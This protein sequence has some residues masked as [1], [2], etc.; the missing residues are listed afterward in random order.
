MREALKDIEATLLVLDLGVFHRVCAATPDVRPED[1]PGGTA[2]PRLRVMTYME[3]VQAF[4]SP[5]SAATRMA[6]ALRDN[7]VP[8]SPRLVAL[9]DDAPQLVPAPVEPLPRAPAAASAGYREVFF[10][11]LGLDRSH[12]RER[13]RKTFERSTDAI[14]LACGDGRQHVDLF[15]QW[16]VRW[17]RSTRKVR[18]IVVPWTRGHERPESEYGWQSL[19]ATALGQGDAAEALQAA[20]QVAP[21]LIE[22]H[23]HPLAEVQLT[24]IDREAL[25]AF[26]ASI[27][28]LA[29]PAAARHPIVALVC[30]ETEDPASPKPAWLIDP[31]VEAPLGSFSFVRL[32]PLRTPT[33]EDVEDFLDDHSPPPPAQVREEILGFVEKH[34]SRDADFY[35]LARLLQRELSSL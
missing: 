7:G 22:V 9:L 11:A 19:L 8:L 21:L 29:G 27:P 10:E 14:L 28:E 20:A 2:G 1:L 25:A 6:K 17:A 33:L 26:L 34:L 12:Q 16:A 23:G 35:N 15:A 3:H 4:C 24:D 18:P 30:V 5:R 32:R 31:L 13:L